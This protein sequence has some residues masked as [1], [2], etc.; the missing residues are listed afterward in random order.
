MEPKPE[1]A[2]IPVGLTDD[3]VVL[4]D[5]DA[6]TENEEKAYVKMPQLSDR[7]GGSRNDSFFIPI[8]DGVE[9]PERVTVVTLDDN[10]EDSQE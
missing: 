1:H 2:E 8:P 3:L 5:E 9:L 10:D 4:D 7:C 6:A